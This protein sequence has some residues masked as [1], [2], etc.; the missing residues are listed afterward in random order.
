MQYVRCYLRSLEVSDVVNASKNPSFRALGDHLHLFLS[1]VPYYNPSQFP[2][3]TLLEELTT[4]GKPTV[5]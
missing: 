2:I 3:T 4:E 5:V 1:G